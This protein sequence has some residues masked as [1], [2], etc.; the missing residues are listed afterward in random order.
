MCSTA[1]LLFSIVTTGTFTPTTHATSMAL[2][3]P[4]PQTPLGA[5]LF[6]PRDSNAWAQT[7]RPL[8][9]QRSLVQGSADTVYGW[10][11]PD[12]DAVTPIFGVGSGG[13]GGLAGAKQRNTWVEQWRLGS[14]GGGDR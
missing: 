5:T 7:F 13:G 12:A 11:S 4:A 10:V 1:L 3:T 2:S 6:E 9:N 8:G 14:G